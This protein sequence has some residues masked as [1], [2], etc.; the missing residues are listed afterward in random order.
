MR[1]TDGTT[2]NAIWDGR[3]IVVPIDTDGQ[4]LRTVYRKR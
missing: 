1:A 4:T 3:D 2:T